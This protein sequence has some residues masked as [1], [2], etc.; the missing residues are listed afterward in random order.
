MFHAVCVLNI[1]VLEPNS[2]VNVDVDA[3]IFSTLVAIAAAYQLAVETTLKMT[4]TTTPPPLTTTTTTTT[5]L[6]KTTTPDIVDAAKDAA[7]DQ[8]ASKK[9]KKQKIEKKMT[10]ENRR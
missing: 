2:D 4:P 3:A 5:P 9:M 8:I 1:T 7:N 10:M 6:T